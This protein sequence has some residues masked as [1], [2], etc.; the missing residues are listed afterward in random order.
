MEFPRGLYIKAAATGNMVNL[1]SLPPY[2][3]GG[4]RGR[5]GGAWYNKRKMGQACYSSYVGK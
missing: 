3:G 1:F 4:R 5:R 2:G